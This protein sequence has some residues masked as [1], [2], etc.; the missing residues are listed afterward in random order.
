M[1]TAY[2]TVLQLKQYDIIAV[3]TAQY[4][5]QKT[6]QKGFPVKAVDLYFTDGTVWANTP[7]TK[8]VQYIGDSRVTQQ[9]GSDG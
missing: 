3:G 4:T 5:V 7:T 9:V 6:V 1:P 2:V 8:R